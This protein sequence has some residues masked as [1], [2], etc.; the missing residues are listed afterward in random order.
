MNGK[1][2]DMD[3]SFA[4]KVLSTAKVDIPSMHGNPKRYGYQ[5]Q[6]F[7]DI[8]RKMAI[9]AL[10][11]QIPK[12]PLKKTLANDGNAWEWVCPN[13]HIVKITTEHCFCNDCGQALDWSD[14]E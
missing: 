3:Y 2:R 11:K 9:S 7:Y 1:P 8:A 10:K 14:T 6:T 4:I 13:C 12:R 5:N